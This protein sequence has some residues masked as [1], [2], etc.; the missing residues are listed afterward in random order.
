MTSAI[1]NAKTLL[2]RFPLQLKIKSDLAL[3]SF[4]IVAKWP[5]HFPKASKKAM[6]LSRVENIMHFS[7]IRHQE[8]GT[9]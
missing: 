5:L 2:K 4:A 7:G 1:Y 8:T 3:F 9:S 6:L